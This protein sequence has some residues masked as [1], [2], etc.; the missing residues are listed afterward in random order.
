[1]AAFLI[2]PLP[3][4][5]ATTVFARPTPSAKTA[6]ALRYPKDSAVFPRLALRRETPPQRAQ[7]T[8]A[9]SLAIRDSTCVQALASLIRLTAAAPD[10]FDANNQSAVPQ[11]ATRDP[12][13]SLATATLDTTFA[14]RHPVAKCVAI[15][16]A[17]P[18]TRT[19]TTAV[20][21]AAAR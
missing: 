17:P 1:L 10:A 7:A 16:P 8:P 20:L 12:A 18:V 13:A 19:T 21:G 11:H 3:N 6:F 9:D 4:A 14:L 15:N 5:E 2:A